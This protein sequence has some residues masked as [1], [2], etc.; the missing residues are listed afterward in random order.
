MTAVTR[1]NGKSSR[2][3]REYGT[4]SLCFLKRVTITV[5]VVGYVSACRTTSTTYYSNRFSAVTS[6]QV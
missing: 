2:V 1:Y 3:R 5:D 6:N 4:A